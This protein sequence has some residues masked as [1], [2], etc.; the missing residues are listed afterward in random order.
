M[1]ICALIAVRSGSQRVKNKNIKLFAKKTSLLE[2]KV[3]QAVQS[4]YLRNV[5]VS[6]DSDEML[7]LAESYD[8]IGIKRDSY[9]ASNTVPMNSV[10][11]YMAKQLDCEHIVYLHVTSPLLKN[12]TLDHCIEKYKCLDPKNYDSL[13]TVNHL[14]E[15]LWKDGKPINYNPGEHPRSQDLPEVFSL[16]FAVNII[17]R[18][19]M[20]KQKNIIGKSFYPIVMDKEESIDV[21]TEFEF[22]IAEFLYLKKMKEL[23]NE[24]L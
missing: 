15:Y 18:E 8:A 16:N 17:S 23:K 12:Q 6:S 1:D 2:I 20:I 14:H 19:K 22:N 9:F 7:K 5:Y 3:S 13:A 11:E 10:Y 24:Q 21:D 4:K